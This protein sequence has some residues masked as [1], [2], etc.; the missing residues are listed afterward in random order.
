M[1]LGQSVRTAWILNKKRAGSDIK[2]L[3][4]KTTAELWEW[5]EALGSRGEEIEEKCTFSWRDK[6][7]RHTKRQSDEE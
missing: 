6:R 2:R 4:A 3:G 7:V 1:V 5:K